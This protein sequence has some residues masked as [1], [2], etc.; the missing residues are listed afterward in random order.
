MPFN[1]EDTR[2]YR[3]DVE[4][5]GHTMSTE[6]RRQLLERYLPKPSNVQSA[7]KSTTTSPK[8][9]SRHRRRIRP[10]L[11][12]TLHLLLYLTIQFVFGV[13][14][15]IR[16]IIS[17][18]FQKYIAIRHYHHRTP[19]YIQKDLKNLSRLPEHLSVILKYDS[20]TD[21]GLETLLDEVAELSAWSAA[22][23]IPLLSVYEKSGIL[24]Q[25][26]SALHEIVQQKLVLY[27]GA[28]PSTPTLRVLAPNHPS[29]SPIPSPTIPAQTNGTTN[30]NHRPTNISLNLLLLSESDGRATLVDLT[31][32]LAEMAQ[33]H[34][35]RPKDIT[36]DLIDT[37]IT[38]TTSIPALS[39]PTALA[40][41]TLKRNGTS[42]SVPSEPDLL[43][44]FAPY[45]KLDGYPP[46]QIR[47]TEIFCVGDSGG[48]VSGRLRTR[49]EYQGFLRALWNFA[50][51]E[52]RFGR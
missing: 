27:F 5:K 48:D 1:E 37:E 13:Y 42:S 6:E 16:Q 35:L 3:Q 52:F 14:I 11:K 51:A 32:T 17:A 15:R 33:A 49:V 9:K 4:T 21:D 12:Q 23:G 26:M 28:P 10:F 40:N 34:K 45:I 38:A 39:S 24:K 36:Q 8:R 20:S 46:W 50:G 2:F 31:R 22:A 30:G 7:R 18:L 41:G 43:I 25:Y 19:A 44:V 29:L 47:L